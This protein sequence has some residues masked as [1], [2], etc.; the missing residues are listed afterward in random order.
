MEESLPSEAN[1]SS[2]SQ[3]FIR[4]LWRRLIPYSQESLVSVAYKTNALHALPSCLFRIHFNIIH[5]RVDL[6]GGPLSQVSP[7]NSVCT[8]ISFRRHACPVL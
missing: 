3:D 4:V 1:S 7:P 2:A 5:L 6:P 8:R